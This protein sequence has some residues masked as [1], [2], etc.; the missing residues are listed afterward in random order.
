MA[1]VFQKMIFSNANG[2][3]NRYVADRGVLLATTGRF[4]IPPD[5]TPAQAEQI[6]IAAGANVNVDFDSVCPE[7]SFKMRKLVFIRQSGNSL[8]VPIGNRDDLITARNAIR[9][10]LNSQA[11]NQVVCIRLVGEEFDAMNDE[12]GVA[13]DGEAVATS[14]RP[15]NGSKQFVYSGSIRYRTDTTPGG[16][17]VIT[18][19]VKVDTENEGNPPACLGDVWEECAGLLVPAR[20]N[21]GGA[22]REHRRYLIDFAVREGEN[23]ENVEGDNTPISAQ[24]KELPV[25]AWSES[26]ILE[27]GQNAAALTGVFCISYRGESFSRFHTI[28]G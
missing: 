12:L 19:S 13:W 18:T 21:C 23:Q 4:A 6:A 8:S 16:S 26:E 15:D 7:A 10:I 25:S 17:V 22:N 5:I 14:S 20:L 27:C 24:R 28:Q 2:L 3:D 9:G 11:N 1:R